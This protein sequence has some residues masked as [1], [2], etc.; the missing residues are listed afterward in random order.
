MISEPHQF[1]DQF[2]SKHH[3]PQAFEEVNFPIHEEVHIE[4]DCGE[5]H[6]EKVEEI[7]VE[8]DNK[9]PH[10]NNHVS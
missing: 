7:P 1:V 8:Q 3:E 5:E 6:V 10:P 9:L 2:L 4:E